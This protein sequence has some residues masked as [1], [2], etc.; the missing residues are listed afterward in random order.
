M[1]NTKIPKEAS[2]YTP[3]ARRRNTGHPRKGQ[4]VE[5]ATGISPMSL[6]EGDDKYTTI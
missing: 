5:A 2:H 4:K 3:K 6:T 1:W